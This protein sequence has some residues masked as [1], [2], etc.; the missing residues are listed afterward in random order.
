MTVPAV[1]RVTPCATCPYR[2][3]VPSG[4]WH[5]DEYSKLQPYDEETYAQPL[6]AFYCHQADG[7][8][9]SGWVA[10]GDRA[11]EL[12]ALRIGVAA[13]RIDPSVFDYTTS[14]PLHPS[15]TA[16]AEHGRAEIPAPS[17]DAILAQKKL[18]KSRL[19]DIFTEGER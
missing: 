1:P 12:I 14:V 15:G 2:K 3:S 4:I 10:C 7:H 17:I 13:G 18:I 19:L 6:E 8:L 16:A 11:D 5:E 9:C